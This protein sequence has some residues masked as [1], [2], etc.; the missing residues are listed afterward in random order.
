[1]V[2]FASISPPPSNAAPAPNYSSFSSPTSAFNSP[3]IASQPAARPAPSGYQ[4]SQPNYFTSVQIPSQ[5]QQ[6]FGNTSTTSSVK[7]PAANKPAASG[8]D[9]FGNLWSSASAGVKK[10]STPTAG[11]ALGQLAKEKASAG[12]WGAPAQNTYQ[13]PKPAQGGQQQKMGNGLDDLLG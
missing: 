13:A 4:G 6:P 10:T 2:G 3:P 5:Q 11:P 8:G 7:S 9:A 1:M 12:I